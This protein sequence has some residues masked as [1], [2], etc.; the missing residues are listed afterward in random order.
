MTSPDDT[1]AETKL[2]LLDEFAR[3]AKAIAHPRRLELL[4]LL[5][6]AER[7]VDVLADATAMSVAN[8]SA[9]LQVLRNAQL[10]ETRKEGTRV[11]YRL[12]GGDV[13]VLLDALR[14]VA[15]T[16]LAEV[17]RIARD[18]FSARDDLEPISSRELRTRAESGDV[19]VLDVR[20]T[21]EFEAGHIPGAI[22]IPLDELDGRL[23]EL[24]PDADVVAYCRNRYCVLAPE[25]VVRL[26]RRGRR[27]RRL[28]EGLPEWRAAGF[29]VVGAG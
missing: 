8:T 22:S 2:A 4:D 17:D 11:H 18:F 19:V 15:A 16:H 10:V 24:D 13:S 6:Q 27:A 7:S 20:P 1:A 9:H 26:R 21:P 29:P 28:D 3:I 5:A 14:V 12:A 25:A 23:D